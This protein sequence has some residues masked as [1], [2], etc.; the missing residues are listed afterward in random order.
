MLPSP[1]ADPRFGRFGLRTECPTCG[2]HLPVNGPAAEVSCADCGEGVAVPQEVLSR[3][4][5]GFEEAFPEPVGAGSLTVGDKTWRW[6][7]A[8]VDGPSCP[9]CARPLTAAPGDGALACPGCA[10]T[11]PCERLPAA[12]SKIV[13]ASA[14]VIGGEAD[15][16][17]TE[18][19]ARPVALGCPNCG[20][21]L[22]ITSQHHRITTC[23][24]C[25]SQVHVPDVVWRAL[26]PPRTVQQWFVRFQGE[27]RPAVR[28]RRERETAERERLAKEE[29]AQE[30]VV[31]EARN[32][33]E[34]DEQARLDEAENA[35]RAVEAAA[36]HV[37]ATRFGRPLLIA[38]AV[39]ALVTTGLQALATVWFT[40]GHT[41]LVRW[42][43]MRPLAVNVIEDLLVVVALVAMPVAWVL[44]MAAATRRA[45]TS[46][47]E[48]LPWGLFMVFLSAIPFVGVFFSLVFT[49]QHLVGAE[50]TIGLGPRVPRFSA[51]PLA[52]LYLTG[53]FFVYVAWGALTRSALGLYTGF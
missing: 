52:L 43:G 45:G 35:R 39:A 9:A 18:Q 28:A 19:P 21:G 36:A 30:R 22:S 15:Q 38:A 47:F 41:A 46:F 14:W 32:R 4:L 24:R 16:A 53:G 8:V 23:D 44:G 27:S 37:R 10:A 6:T 51:W 11:I 1:S 31:R 29:R 17:R 3:L 42:L 50:P 40:V 2:A 26:H 25:S 20:A 49:R 13:R 5:D 34:L 7:T 33:A 12:L 48:V